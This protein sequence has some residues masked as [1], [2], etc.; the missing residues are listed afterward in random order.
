MPRHERYKSKTGY[1]H[2]M[3]RGNERKNIF[4][5][6]ED[7]LRFIETLDFKK[8]EN[9]FELHAFCLMDNHVHLLISEGTEEIS[10]VMKRVNVSY[11]IYFNKKYKRIGHLFQ[12]RFRSE[13][14]EHE[15]Q[16]ITVARYIHQNPLKAGMVKKI[17]DYKWSSYQWY[18]GN[19]RYLKKLVDTEFVLE[20][21]SYK[22][23]EARHSFVEYMNKESRETYIDFVEPTD[24]MNEEEA[25]EL[26]EKMLVEYS[27]K[28]QAELLKEFRK[29]TGF[30]IREIA[31]IT[32]L[33]RNKVNNLLR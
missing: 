16:A 9:R 30:S 24:K 31:Q 18:I 17:E 28:G 3:M 32:N 6:E 25:H 2:I 22:K 5:D 13:A 8:E 14:I 27:A 1:Y 26:Y 12:D 21:F 23:E 10:N 11:V 29:V 7:K 33:N 4:I 20:M 15:Q 19:P